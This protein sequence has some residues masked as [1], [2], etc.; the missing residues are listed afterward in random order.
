MRLLKSD[1]L[2]ILLGCV[3]GNLSDTPIEWNDKYA[4][5]IVLASG[6]YPG[7]YKK[8]EQIEGIKNTK[9]GGM[10]LFHAGTKDK[11]NEVVTSGGR[12]LSVTAISDTL[13]NALDNAY[14][15]I[16]KINFKGMQ[17]RKDIGSNTLRFKNK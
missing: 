9:E 6:G 13:E 16:S 12:V 5:C 8:G 10:T 17:F 4:C 3:D 1:L 2:D 14:E 7:P 11:N 15:T